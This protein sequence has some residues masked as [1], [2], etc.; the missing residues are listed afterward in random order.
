MDYLSRGKL[1]TTVIKGERPESITL[2]VI[3]VKE[4]IDSEGKKHRLVLWDG[5]D[6]HKFA[7]YMKHQ[8]EDVPPSNFSIIRVSDS[9]IPVGQDIP[10]GIIKEMPGKTEKTFAWVFWHYTLVKDG[11][12]VGGRVAPDDSDDDEFPAR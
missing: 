6:E 5:C 2:Q 10:K 11:S 7:L 3:A 12:K 9:D 4:M 8:N 1:K